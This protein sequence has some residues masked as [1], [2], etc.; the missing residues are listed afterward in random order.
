M[1][2]LAVGA[3]GIIAFHLWQLDRLARWAAESS[4][5]ARARGPRQ[6]AHRLRAIH[7]RVRSRRAFERDLARTIERFRSAAEAIPDG[8]VVLDPQNRIRWANARAEVQFGVDVAHDIGRPLLNLVRQPEVARY[9]D[10][11][12][13]TDAVVVAS[14]RMSGVMLS[15]QIVPFGIDEKLLISPRHHATRSG[16][17]D[18]PRLHRQCLAR[19]EDAVDGDRRLSGNAAG[20]RPRCAPA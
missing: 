17:A 11:A 5:D 7:R 10:R 3:G 14:R 8:I 19:I 12:D 4:R 20:S 15:I 18:A 1:V 9:L 13:F 6:L 2:V 16:G